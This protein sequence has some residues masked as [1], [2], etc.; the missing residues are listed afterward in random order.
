MILVKANSNKGMGAIKAGE[1]RVW[2]NKNSFP[3]ISA[4]N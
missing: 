4:S 2:S 1:T 3:M